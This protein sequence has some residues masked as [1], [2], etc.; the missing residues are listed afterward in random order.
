M[1]LSD[2]LKKIDEDTKKEIASLEKQWQDYL[3]EKEK[4]FAVFEDDFMAKAKEKAHEVAE[5][6]HERL[7]T[8]AESDAGLKVLR[9][10]RELLDR[11]FQEAQS[12]IESL[13]EA[14]KIKVWVKVFQEIPEKKGT[15]I[16][17]TAYADVLG[18]EIKKTYPDIKIEKTDK[19]QEG[20]VLEAGRI[21]YDNRLLPLM[22]QAVDLFQDEMVDFL[23]KEA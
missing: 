8:R 2:I 11:V 13:S 7:I 22:E 19:F 18:K 10:K 15:M 3:A 17:P 4:S 23:F 12:K 1:A 20:F 9:K 6:H 16:I 5:V 14:Q 21:S